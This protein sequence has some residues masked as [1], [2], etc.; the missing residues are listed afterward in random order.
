M[1][2]TYCVD[3]SAVKFDDLASDDGTQVKW[4]QAMPL[5]KWQHPIHGP[6]EITSD[7]VAQ[8]AANVND[9][10]RGQELDIDY[11]H[12]ERIGD[13]AGWVKGAQARPDGLWLGVQFTKNALAKLKEKA[14]RYFSPEFTTKW[15]HPSTGVVHKDVLFGGALT[16][17]PYLKGILPINLSEVNTGEQMLEE[18]RKLLGL[19]DTATEAEVLAAA[20]TRLT[21]EPPKG[22]GGNDDG[23]G[24][25]KTDPPKGEEGKTDPPK[26]KVEP[27]VEPKAEPIAAS[28]DVVK[29]HERI[30]LLEASNRLSEVSVKLSELNAIKD[31]KFALAPAALEQLKSLALDAPTASYQDKL[32][33]FAESVMSKGIVELGERGKTSPDSQGQTATEQ[34]MKLSEKHAEDNKVSMREACEAISMAEPELFSEYQRESYVR[35]RGDES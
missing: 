15:E 27:T 26:P 9:G 11:D 31:K 18:L 35:S 5:G 33:Q 10:V 29:L 24:D 8:F 4:F 21:A 16:N 12:K 7:R 3:L 20:N 32:F 23:K 1:D 13:A 19:P 28:E 6:I 14:Y 22:E 25:G 2:F 34:F 17:R 30:A